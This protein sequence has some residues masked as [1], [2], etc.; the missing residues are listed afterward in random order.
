MQI[1]GLIAAV[2]GAVF[3]VAVIVELLQRD[4]LSVPAR[5]APEELHWA[6]VV[7]ILFICGWM[8]ISGLDAFLMPTSVTP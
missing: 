7:V 8:V 3:L 2:L 5:N 1:L 6:Q 4:G